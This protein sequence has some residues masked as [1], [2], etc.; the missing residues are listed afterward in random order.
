[1]TDLR[2]LPAHLLARAASLP[3]NAAASEALRR[4]AGLRSHPIT[5]EPA[6]VSQ[7]ARGAADGIRAKKGKKRGEPNGT[8]ARFAREVLDPMVLR[9]AL[10]SYECEGMTLR[11]AGVGAV[12]PDF[13]GWRDGV[14]V[15]FEVKAHVVH[16]A[17]VLRMKVHAAARPWLRWRIYARRNGEWRVHFDS[18]L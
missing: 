10:D 14:P 9:G 5:S 6:N 4:A 12:T 7:R 17:S 2:S 1:M 11:I 13:V 15:L 18:R 3:T 8:E 16:E